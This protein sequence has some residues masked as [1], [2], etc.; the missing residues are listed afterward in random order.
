M[1]SEEC[2]NVWETGSTTDQCHRKNHVWQYAERQYLED[3][4]ADNIF[5]NEGL[6]AV[7]RDPTEV[8]EMEME[9]ALKQ[10]LPEILTPK[11]TEDA[12]HNHE[13]FLNDVSDSNT[14]SDSNSN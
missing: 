12:D 11:E 9:A 2:H 10:I 8:L 14:G 1:P 4:Y 7:T 5:A 13:L 3:L 6:L